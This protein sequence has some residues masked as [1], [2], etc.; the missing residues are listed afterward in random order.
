MARKKT[1]KPPMPATAEPKIKPIRLDLTEDEHRALRVIAAKEGKSMAAFVRDY[2][3]ALIEER[4][5]D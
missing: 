1:E 5:D 3:R 2:V 4:R